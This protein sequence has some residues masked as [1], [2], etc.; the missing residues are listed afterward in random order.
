LQRHR[1]SA[2]SA[3]ELIVKRLRSAESAEIEH[4]SKLQIPEESITGLRDSVGAEL[5]EKRNYLKW[6]KAAGLG[7]VA[8]APSQRPLR[9][10]WRLPK[11]MVV[12]AE[13]L[14][15]MAGRVAEDL[16]RE[17]FGALIWAMSEAAGTIEP[18]KSL[19]KLPSDILAA[20]GRM[21]SSG[22]APRLL[23]VPR[24]QR[25]ADVILQR[26]PWEPRERDTG[27]IE[28]YGMWG[29][30]RVIVHPQQWF[31][32]VLIVDVGQAL[33]KNQS[34]AN[35]KAVEIAR[36][37]ELTREQVTGSP[38]P[39]LDGKPDDYQPMVELLISS[40]PVVAV[41]GSQAKLSGIHAISLA[42]TDACYAMWPNDRLYHR[43]TCRR[44][45]NNDELRY[46]LRPCLENDTVEREP[47][48]DCS[49]QIWDFEGRTRATNPPT[50]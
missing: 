43:P 8:N 28:S 39:R 48:P 4:I 2:D 37:T 50:S 27:P 9:S 35:D 47:C 44:V 5:V 13:T 3:I 23:I 38:T 25:F 30:L 15:Q 34:G 36:P 19:A 20:V 29:G 32:R 11:S 41:S 16:V 31:D 18:A 26:T 33:A 45:K 10:T 42:D 24:E 1:N 17:E 21:K 46:R 14:R 7:T 49:P 40:S 22:L 6:M 12:E